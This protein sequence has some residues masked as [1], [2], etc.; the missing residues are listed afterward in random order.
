MTDYEKFIYKSRYARWNEELGRRENWDETVKRYCDFFKNRE[1]GEHFP[2]EE[3]YNAIHN[4]E[5]MPSMR[6]LMTAGPALER[7]N[8]AG[9]NCSFIPI[10]SLRAFDEIMY[11]LMCGTGVGFSVEEKYVS[12]LPVVA[13]TFTKSG[14]TIVVPDS[15]TGWASSLRELVSLLYSGRI[16]EIDY[17]RVRPAGAR[18]KTFGGRASGPE[19]LQRLYTYTC[20][21][22]SGARGRKLT[23]LECHD[24]ACKIADVVIVG[25]VRRSAL[26]SLSDLGDTRLQS[27][28]NGSWW[29][30]EPQRALANNSAV[31]NEK[32]P[33]EAFLNEWSNLYGSKSGERGI[34]NQVASR[35]QVI[36]SGRRDPEHTFGTNP[37][38]EIILRPNGLCNLSEVIVRPKDSLDDLR[39]KVRIASIIG[40]FQSMLTDFRYVRKV[41][42]T[43]AEEERL[44]G[45]SFTGIFDNHQTLGKLP[46][47]DSTLDKNSNPHIPLEKA[48]EVLRDVAIK[49]NE[50]YAARI[51]I[52]ASAAITC[53]KPSGTV[54]QLV[55]CSSGIHPSF[56]P[57]YYRTVRLDNKD[58]LCSFLKD[59]GLKNEP[60][61][62]HPDSQTVFYFPTKS[63]GVPASQVGAMEHLR[64]YKAYRTH[65]CEHNPSV[66]IYYK[67][68]EFLEIGNWIWNNWDD[69]GGI[70]FLPHSDHVYEQAPYI[71]LTE[72]E[73]V[74]ALEEVK[75]INW[76][77]F[78]EYEKED[79]TTNSHDL[80]C[81]AGICEIL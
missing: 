77:K 33:M 68:S 46:F 18:L 50:D 40:T 35:K 7:D 56:S 20:S 22:I 51:G 24:L 34:F 72:V 3:V 64:L 49:T 12:Q 9:Y 67:D 19:P 61:K 39:R 71:E 36:K 26:I 32:P 1:G 27:A 48:L 69:I 52:R 41:W 79:A 31:Y 10:D 6:A 53:V 30:L 2:Y 66:T 65:W 16:P 44:L 8:I 17:S 55:G 59:Q 63:H 14:T 74:K 78:E 47:Y 38:G 54:S 5:V 73:Y 11:I 81:S 42:R 45:V 57:Y 58:P 15:R 62:F 29:D 28:K 13:E 37:C 70:A 25:G 43:N 76:A 23:T 21:L 4:M 60:E 80:A 75:E